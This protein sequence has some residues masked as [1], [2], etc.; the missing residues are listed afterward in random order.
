MAPMLKDFVKVNA[1]ARKRFDLLAKNEAD[2][3][4]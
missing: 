2:S 4:S 3:A 1:S